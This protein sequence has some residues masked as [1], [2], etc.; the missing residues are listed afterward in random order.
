MNRKY[1]RGYYLDLIRE[2][3]AQVKDIAV[4]SD[5]IVGF[6]SE[7]E[8]E[9]EETLDLVAQAE[10]DNIF[11]F[12]YSRRRDTPAEKMRDDVTRKEK[13]DRFARL[14]KLQNEIVLKK[15]KALEGRIIKVL[16]ES[17]YKNMGEGWLA[18]RTSQYKLAAFEGSGE[19]IG[20]FVNVK[21]NEGRLHGL[22]GKIL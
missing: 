22:Y 18:G 19:L 3:K 14:V 15:N 1:T 2:L 8:Q 13:T 9:F 5:I 17:E 4:T 11:P 12:I 21:I 16:V 6:P 7:T 20:S 10:F